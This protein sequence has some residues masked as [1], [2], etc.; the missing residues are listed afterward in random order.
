LPYLKTGAAT[1]LPRL[2]YN[3]GRPRAKRGIQPFAVVDLRLTQRRSRLKRSRILA[4]ESLQLNRRDVTP[5]LWNVVRHSLKATIASDQGPTSGVARAI[6]D[7]PPRDQDRSPPLTFY[8]AVTGSSSDFQHE[9]IQ[10]AISALPSLRNARQV[11]RA[12]P[13]RRRGL[14]T[15]T[16]PFGLHIAGAILGSRACCSRHCSAAC[17]ER[18]LCGPANQRWR[19]SRHWH[20]TYASCTPVAPA[21]C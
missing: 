5:N 14:R 8:I 7:A 21:D 6:L 3:V 17:A 18:I 10:A 15:S 1:A 13:Q 9:H 2:G 19:C 11:G 12:N 16:L 20:W 4:Y